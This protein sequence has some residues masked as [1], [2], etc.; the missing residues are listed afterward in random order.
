M[1]LLFLVLR[2]ERA[3]SVLMVCGFFALQKYQSSHQIIIAYSG[4]RV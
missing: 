2:I 3:R 4:D 1:V